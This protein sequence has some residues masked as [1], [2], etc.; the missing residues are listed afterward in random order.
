MLFKCAC[1][2]LAAT[3]D[4]GLQDA[5]WRER[6]LID[7]DADGVRHRVDK[8]RRK[9]RQCAF[10]GLFGPKRSGG[11]TGFD[12]LNFDRWLFGDRRHAVL[13]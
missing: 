4:L 9:A 3:L 6:K 2:G 10:A 8:S 5:V 11:I 1:T 13:E 7:I 12:N